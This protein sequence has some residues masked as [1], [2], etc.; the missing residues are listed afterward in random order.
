[1][2]IFHIV[3]FKFKDDL[4]KEVVEKASEGMVTLEAKLL[5]PETKK[6]YVR[7]RIGGINNS[8]EGRARGF[9]HGY[10]CEFDNEEDRTYYLEADPAHI[11]WV[12]YVKP[13]IADALVVDFVNG[14]HV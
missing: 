9:T 5:H 1:M 3:L 4:S 6:P 13:F 10:I 7:N 12:Q 8:P 2:S 11:E 14:V